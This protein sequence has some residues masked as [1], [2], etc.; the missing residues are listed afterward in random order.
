MKNN[1][2][3]FFYNDLCPIDLAKVLKNSY[4]LI[5]IKE[6]DYKDKC[7]NSVIKN[8]YLPNI[9]KESFINGLI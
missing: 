2:N 3:A 8:G 6:V 4:N 9:M 1:H 7:V 5:K